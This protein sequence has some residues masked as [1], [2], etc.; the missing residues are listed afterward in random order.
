MM[1]AMIL[2][3]LLAGAPATDV[4]ID[5]GRGK[6]DSMPQISENWS[7]PTPAMVQEVRKILASGKCRMDGQS[8]SHFDITVPF[9]V[10]LRADGS[11]QH[12]V[13]GDRGCPEVETMVGETVV[14]LAALGAFKGKNAGA[15]KWYASEINF[16]LQ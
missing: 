1:S 6:F 16:T 9:A 10:E 12:I 15:T 5:T 8:A 7:L 13:V 3:M 4:R 11:T 2:S 14:K